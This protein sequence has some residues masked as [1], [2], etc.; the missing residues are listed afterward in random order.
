MSK[1]VSSSFKIRDQLVNDHSSVKKTTSKCKFVCFNARSLRNKLLDLVSILNEYDIL[2]ITETWLSDDV[3]DVELG[4]NSFEVFRCDR[5]DGYGGVAILVKHGLVG[6][7]ISL[8]VC[9]IDAIAVSVMSAKYKAICVCFYRPPSSKTSDLEGFLDEIKPFCTTVENLILAGDANLPLVDWGNM[10][11][12]NRDKTGQVFLDFC[13]DYGMTQFVKEPTHIAGNI[14]DVV[15]ANNKY[16]VDELEVIA[17]FSTSDHYIVKFSSL[18]CAYSDKKKN[19]MV[20][21]Y[22]DADFVGLTQFLLRIDWIDQ[23]SSLASV[24]EM[25][26]LFVDAILTGVDI[27]VPTIVL[28]S[29]QRKAFRISKETVQ[30]IKVKNL[31]WNQARRHRSRNLK[32]EATLASRRVTVS[33]LKDRKAF[34]DCLARKVNSKRFYTYVRS[35]LKP[36]V[37][38]SSILNNGNIVQY[39]KVIAHLF[40][41]Y[42]ASVFTVDNGIRYTFPNL[43]DHSLPMINFDEQKICRALKSL[44]LKF[45]VGPD[46]ISSYLLKK[47]SIAVLKPLTLIF[48]ATYFRSEVPKLWKQAII[49]PIFKGKGSRQDVSSY[50]PI[51]LTC[52]PCKLFEKI[53]NDEILKY[54]KAKG[55]IVDQQHGFLSK[56]STLTQLLSCQL[57]W[58][59]DSDSGKNIDVIYLDLAKAFDTVC[60][61]QLLIKLNAY[62]INGYAHRWIESFLG[63][64]TQAVKI[65]NI[66]S[67]YS[68]VN[69]GVPQ[70]SVLGPT[71]F[72]IYIND[73]PS[74]VEHS[75]IMMYAD[76]TK[77]WSSYRRDEVSLLQ[78]DLDHVRNWMMKWQLKLNVEKS[79][80]LY[81]GWGNPRNSCL[82]EDKEISRSVAQK[83]LGVIVSSDMKHTAH[84]AY[85]ASK[86]VQRIGL[87]FRCFKTRN[88]DCLI[89]LYKTY[90][91]PILEY[92][93]PIWSP[94]LLQDI[95]RIENVQRSFLRRLSGYEDLSY[96]ERLREANLDSL[97]LR[98]IKHD[99]EF[100]F[101]LKHHFYDLKFENLFETVE[102]LRTRGHRIKLRKRLCNSNVFLF[103]FCNRVVDVWNA[104][105]AS[106]VDEERYSKFKAKIHL[107]KNVLYR[108]TK[109]RTL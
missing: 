81:L 58:F 108:F 45:S 21:N 102:N 70:G 20:H 31:K 60:H 11:T 95:D 96:S 42:F 52:V 6:S 83:D 12:A 97:E 54:L 63:E 87:I 56:R 64:R 47:L 69:S 79:S 92:N 28:K 65:G 15:L 100:V 1:S 37:K 8:K 84:C 98:R 24:D 55:L 99:L 67:G 74:S 88:P 59:Q 25:Y 85:V 46:G 14:L 57:N 35:I 10:L 7:R 33:L 107:H 9:G 16:I 82:W 44:P 76:D 71:L 53:V 93:S 5:A 4:Q 94:H 30:A 62:G 13:V 91:R 101:K 27:F 19:K 66:L 50:R 39:E 105:P 26:N 72:L 104:L 48:Q 80:I 3:F 41:D 90:I 109:G 49:S 18:T 2:M 106:V 78:L 86:A 103:A 68:R 17:P 38:I 36:K 73:L 51:S 77:I 23:F 75:S 89:R 29:S 40:N 61:S 34:E 32:K 22:R 43:T